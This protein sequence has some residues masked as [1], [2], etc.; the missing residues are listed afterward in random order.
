[1]SRMT[2]LIAF[3][4]KCKSISATIIT[5]NSVKISLMGMKALTKLKA[6]VSVENEASKM[7]CN[8]AREN[9]ANSSG[10]RPIVFSK[11]QTTNVIT[12]SKIDI[13]SKKCF[14]Y[15]LKP[16]KRNR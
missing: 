10:K 8:D 11:S 16:K 12:Q 15:T 3:Q 1:M 2:Y 14:L 13:I 4:P 6:C 7:P 5:P 9:S